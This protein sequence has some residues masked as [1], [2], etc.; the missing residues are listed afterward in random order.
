MCAAVGDE[1][2]AATGVADDKVQPVADGRALGINRA[3]VEVDHATGIGG[4]ELLN[5]YGAAGDVQLGGTVVA[6]TVHG[7]GAVGHGELAAADVHHVVGGT[8]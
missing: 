5:H 2:C 3:A 4:N 7:Q 6:G 8:G 1:G